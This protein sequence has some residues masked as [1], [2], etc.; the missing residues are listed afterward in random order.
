MLTILFQE[1]GFLNG[2]DSNK[3]IKWPKRI[4]L[5]CQYSVGINGFS[6]PSPPSQGQSNVAVCL[7]SYD[8][9]LLFIVE[10]HFPQKS[11]P[12]AYCLQ[13]ISSA[14]QYVT[15]EADFDIKLL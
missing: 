10:T 14:C 2:S 8:T 1:K 15:R 12:I 11:C 7:S 4:N 3:T 13:V 9:T 5:F 6:T